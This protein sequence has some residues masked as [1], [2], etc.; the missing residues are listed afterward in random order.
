MR[1]RYRDIRDRESTWREMN[2]KEQNEKEK[3]FNLDRHVRVMLC[4]SGPAYSSY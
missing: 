4:F 2:E 1:E 3:R